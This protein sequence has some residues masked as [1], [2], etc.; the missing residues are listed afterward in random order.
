MNSKLRLSDFGL[1]NGINEVIGVTYGVCDSGNGWNTAPLG[2]IVEDELG[3]AAKVRLFRSH[4]RENVERS[5]KI[6]INVVKDPL[7]FAISAFEDL[8]MDHFSNPPV[9]RKAVAFCEFDAEIEGSFAK[10]TL[11]SGR[12]FDEEIRKAGLSAV[13]RGFHAVIEGLVYATRLANAK[14]RAK[15]EIESFVYHYWHIVQRCGG[16]REKKAYEFLMDKLR[17]QGLLE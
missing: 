2:I 10:L 5:G 1:R 4:T 7:L 3:D 11:K 8:S 17:R 13:N 15:E 16:E 6:Y 9:L 14:G 12:V